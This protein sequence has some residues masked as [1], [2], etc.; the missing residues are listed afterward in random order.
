MDK[1]VNFN[2]KREEVSEFA[3]SSRAND[4]VFVMARDTP[5]KQPQPQNIN[6]GEKK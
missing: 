5:V 4:K 2:E 3:E 6:S 1:K